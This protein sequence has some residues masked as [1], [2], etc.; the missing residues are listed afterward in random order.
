[1]NNTEFLEYMKTHDYIDKSDIVLEKFYELS[2][3]ARKI[4]MELNNKYHTQEEIRELFSKL[5][6][7]K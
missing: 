7:K 6:N 1:M 2:E 5:T 4:T 3:D